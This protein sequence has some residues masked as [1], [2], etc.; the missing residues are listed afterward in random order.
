MRDHTPHPPTKPLRAWL[1]DLSHARRALR[2]LQAK[3]GET[4]RAGATQNTAY[5][6]ARYDAWLEKV[7]A[8]TAPFQLSKARTRSTAATRSARF[9]RELDKRASLAKAQDGRCYLC[10]G[11]FTPANPPTLEHVKPRARGGKRAG[12]LLVAHS[13]CNLLKA[14]RLPTDREMA[15]LRLINERTGR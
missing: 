5:G 13:A 8:G 1:R 15:Y 7:K 10:D 2:A 9:I 12:N 14:D 6:G 3:Y 4:I 11:L